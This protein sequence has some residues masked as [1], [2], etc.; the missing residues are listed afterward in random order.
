MDKWRDLFRE[1]ADGRRAE[2]DGQSNSPLEI[3]DSYSL[4]RIVFEI[5][6]FSDIIAIN[7]SL[8]ESFRALVGQDAPPTGLIT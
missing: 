7:D 5:G 3:G 2:K 1:S 4:I 8:Q 6:L